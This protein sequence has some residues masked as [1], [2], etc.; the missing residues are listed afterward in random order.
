MRRL[1]AAI[2][3]SVAWLS[4]ANAG[5]LVRYSCKDCA[6]SFELVPGSGMK[7][8]FGLVPMICRGKTEVTLIAVRADV[9]SS[10]ACPGG[11][12]RLEFVTGMD[13]PMCPGSKLEMEVIG[14]SD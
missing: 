4:D 5:A 6:R 11:M 2:L 12:E 9:S 1:A 10:P 8:Q 13:C 14:V 3:V 7:S